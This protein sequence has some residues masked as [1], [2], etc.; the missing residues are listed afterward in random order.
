MGKGRVIYWVLFGRPDVK[1]PLE[2]LRS[3]WDDNI[4]MDFREI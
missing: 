1:R 3:S 2:K 4:K